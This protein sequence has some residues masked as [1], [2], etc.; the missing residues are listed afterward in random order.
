[1]RFLNFAVYERG[2]AA[3]RSRAPLWYTSERTCIVQTKTINT[4]RRKGQIFIDV[5]LNIHHFSNF[6]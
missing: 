6:Y 2:A 3:R 4:R 5:M 1:M